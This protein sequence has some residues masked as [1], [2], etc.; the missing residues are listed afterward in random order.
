MERIILYIAALGLFA[1][2]AFFIKKDWPKKYV[3]LALVL[4][5]VVLLSAQ[6]WFQGFFKTQVISFAFSTMEKYGEKLDDFHKTTGKM[7]VEISS[8]HEKLDQ[9]QTDIGRHQSNLEETADD[10]ASQQ[11]EL[12]Q[13]HNELTGFKDLL[14]TNQA[15]ITEQQTE[16]SKTQEGLTKHQERLEDVELLVKNMFEQYRTEHFSHKVPERMIVTKH[17][18]LKTVILF[19]LEHAPI[20]QTMRLQ[21]HIYAQPPGSFF[22]NGNVVMFRW[23]DSVEKTREKSYSMSYVPDPTKKG[24]KGDLGSTDGF[25]TVDGKRLMLNGKPFKLVR[26]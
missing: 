19:E 4:S 24:R 11:H 21:Y 20:P 26:N 5:V 2:T 18:D 22:N 15:S 23:G 13:F 25:A 10:I 7:Q 14:V 12:K 6:E 1:L 9:H 3:G 16:I 8:A 17:E